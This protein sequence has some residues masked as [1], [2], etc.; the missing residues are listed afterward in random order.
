MS[1]CFQSSF[2]LPPDS[3][4]PAKATLKGQL[5]PF[6]F[7]ASAGAQILNSQTPQVPLRS[8]LS[9]QSLST[10]SRFPNFQKKL[11]VWQMFLCLC[12]ALKTNITRLNAYVRA[13]LLSRQKPI[14]YQ[15]C[16]RKSANSSN[17]SLRGLRQTLYTSDD[18]VEKDVS[19]LNESLRGLGA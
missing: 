7:S 10:I 19:Q 17:F 5:L 15:E 16:F 14:A 13:C 12:W 2:T 9:H 4:A 8:S 18:A 1:F 6:I 3:F 11:P